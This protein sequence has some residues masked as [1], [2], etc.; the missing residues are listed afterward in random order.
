MRPANVM[1]ALRYL[2]KNHKD[3]TNININKSWVDD[4]YA[5]DKALAKSLIEASD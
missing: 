3:Y 5:D 1:A 4:S 2:K